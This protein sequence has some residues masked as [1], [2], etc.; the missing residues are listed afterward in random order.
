MT[1]T[2]KNIPIPARRR[3]GFTLIEL[4]IVVAVIVGYFIIT[5]YAQRL[6]HYAKSAPDNWFN[7]FDF[8]ARR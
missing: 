6:E 3:S 7:F 8:W 1:K 5:A 4:M 2:M